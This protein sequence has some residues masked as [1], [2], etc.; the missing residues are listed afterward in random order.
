VVAP[1]PASVTAVLKKRAKR[2]FFLAWNS[3]SGIGR[4]SPTYFIIASYPH[5]IRNYSIKIPEY[6]FGES[7]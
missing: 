3:I 5:H 1:Q 2:M 7:S 6:S 4:F